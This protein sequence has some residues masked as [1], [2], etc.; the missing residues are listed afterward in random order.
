M[1]WSVYF[2]LQRAVIIPL[3]CAVT[4]AAGTAANT[5]VG[6]LIGMP[7]ARDG[8]HD[9]DFEVG[10]WKMS[11]SGNG[12]VVRKLWDGATIAQLIVPRPAR[13]V[14]GSLLTIYRPS[15]REWNIYWADAGDGTV[16]R[17]LIGHFHDSVGIFI[18]HDSLNGR[19][20]LIRLV[21]SHISARSF[22]TVQSE[23]VDNGRTW[24]GERT[25]IYSRV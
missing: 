18:G 2:G 10:T 5:P 7:D 12:H 3:L 1:F 16:S 21:F 15:S 23:S 19:P 22:Q 17:P 11:P 20:A 8:R 24:A 9:F 13:H 25:E 6:A 4:L 14:R